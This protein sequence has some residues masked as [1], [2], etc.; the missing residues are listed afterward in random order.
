M[1]SHNKLNLKMLRRKISTEPNAKNMNSTEASM[2]RI[3]SYLTGTLEK[4]LPT[5]RSARYSPLVPKDF[6]DILQVKSGMDSSILLGA[7]LET[8]ESRQYQKCLS[9]LTIEMLPPLL[10]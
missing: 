8:Q 6:R 4:P 5:P 1:N 7:I 9:R 10:N 2:K 3:Y